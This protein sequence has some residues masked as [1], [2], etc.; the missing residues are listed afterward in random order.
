MVA[1]TI[2]NWKCGLKGP[3][4]KMLLRIAV[5]HQ[6]TILDTNGIAIA[7]SVPEPVLIR[8]TA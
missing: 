1:S 5:A 2:S 7:V 6:N 8:Q 4:R 3:L